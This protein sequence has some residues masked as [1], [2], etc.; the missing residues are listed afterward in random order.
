M[1]LKSILCELFGGEAMLNELFGSKFVLSVVAPGGKEI[2][3]MPALLS[4]NTKEGERE[5]RL[6]WFTDEYV[7]YKHYDLDAAEMQTL[8]DKH[9]LP[10]R[11][12]D[13]IMNYMHLKGNSLKLLKIM[14]DKSGD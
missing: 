1:L 7:P 8:I 2:K 12:S 11:I 13:K 3:Q 9:I 4:K 6:T 10:D 5:Y 14:P